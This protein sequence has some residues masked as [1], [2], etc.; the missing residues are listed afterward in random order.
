VD[1]LVER[2]GFAA[3][4]EYFRLFGK[5]NDRERS[6]LGAFGEPV[7]IFEENFSQH[8]KAPTGG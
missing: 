6:F 1:S 7:A 4:V 3:V 5:L 2:K 8:L